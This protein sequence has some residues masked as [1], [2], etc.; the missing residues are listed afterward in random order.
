MTIGW[1]WVPADQLISPSVT[2]VAR[3]Q[4][5]RCACDDES[6]FLANLTVWCVFKVDGHI[7]LQCTLCDVTY[8]MREEPCDVKVE[9]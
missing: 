6:D 1:E 9:L 2:L 5:P 3:V 8:C 7:H 4:M